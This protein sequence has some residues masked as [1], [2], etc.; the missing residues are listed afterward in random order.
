MRTWMARRLVWLA[1]LCAGAGAASGQLRPDQ[2]LVVYDSR[3]SDSRL[4]AEHYAGSAKVSGGVGSVAGT[5]P[6]VRVFDLA[7]S[8]A[9]VTVPG[10]ITYANYISRIRTPLR[11]YLSSSGLTTSVRCLVMT[12][13]LPH[14][15][16]DTDNANSGDS[17]SQTETEFFNRDVTNAAMEAELTLLWQDLSDGE[18]GGPSDSF[19]DGMIVNPWWGRSE[20][21]NA[22]LSDHITAP[23]AFVAAFTPGRYW[24][25]TSTDPDDALAP[26]DVYLVC[27]LDG[28]SVADVRSMLDRSVHVTVDMDNSVVVLDESDSDGVV[29]PSPPLD[30]ELDNQHAIPTTNGGD[31]YERTRDLLTA[32]GRVMFINIW[33]DAD[34]G[35][36]NFIVGP[37]VSFD[38]EDRKSVV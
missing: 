24:T 15:I 4:V 2:V 23:K 36:D 38:G 31:D 16:R 18:A 21:V 20:P 17:P 28:N 26:G 34:A 12:K 11:D 25:T 35:Q 19:A 33:Y 3:I 10:T 1:A 9:T 30:T 29:T 7:S 8:G 27:R 5:R 37:R 13:G 6:G 22:W 32:D 14:R